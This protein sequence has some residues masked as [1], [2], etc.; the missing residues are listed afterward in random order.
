MKLE[1]EFEC[2]DGNIA[3]KNVVGYCRYHKGYLTYAQTKVHRCHE[4][5]CK[6]FETLGDHLQ[7]LYYENELGAYIKK[8]T[9]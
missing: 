8:I 1:Y 9:N 7:F 2:I 3:K 4:R 6:K 5:K